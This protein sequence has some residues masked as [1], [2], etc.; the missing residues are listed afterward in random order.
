TSSVGTPTDDE[1]EP[2][3]ETPATEE[4][5][6]E[7]T[8]SEQPTVTEEEESDL[9]EQTQQ[10]LAGAYEQLED[11][12]GWTDEGNLLIDGLLAEITTTE[13]GLTTINFQQVS[14]TTEDGGTEGVTWVATEHGIIAKQ[15]GSQQ[16]AG[17][18]EL[19]GDQIQFDEGTPI[20]TVLAS[21]S[22][23]VYYD[24]A[25]EGSPAHYL[26]ITDNQI[27]RTRDDG[28]V[29]NPWTEISDNRDTGTRT[30]LHGSSDEGEDFEAN[31]G[32]HYNRDGNIEYVMDFD[33][34]R[35]ELL[36]RSGR[37][38]GLAYQNRD[39]SIDYYVTNEDGS[40]SATRDGDP[41]TNPLPERVAQAQERADSD[42]ATEVLQSIYTATSATR[43]FPALSNLIFGGTGVQD[44]LSDAEQKF[45]PLLGEVW[46][47]A[48]ICE[49]ARGLDIEPEGV[50]ILR[51]PSGIDNAVAS[52][53]VER[54]GNPS[55]ILCSRNPDEL[56][57]EEFV[58]G[59]D[60]VCVEQFCYL[61][62]ENGRQISEDPATGYFYKITWG[63]K[64][65]ADERLTPFR[66][67][68]AA[69]SFNVYL[70][71]GT[72][73]GTSISDTPLYRKDGDINGPIRLKNGQSDN[74][75]KIAYST[76]EYKKACIVW[77]QHPISRG[78]REPGAGIGTNVE[79]PDLCYETDISKVGI[80]N[81]EKSG[82]QPSST[83]SGGEVE[84]LD[85]Y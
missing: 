75:L 69:V 78:D 34:E 79:M 11:R 62:D 23:T 40:L 74:Q 25:E 1:P 52:I 16:E 10:D 45:T 3:E 83:V 26:E 29:I 47:P 6:E 12:I 70:T 8:S 77:D 21:E 66:D 17:V 67:E 27:I 43:D 84:E 57:E 55:P 14:T 44:W 80:V 71:E 38:V 37:I 20:E 63:V 76:A 56:A 4:P 85:I 18:A 7:S 54:S 53:Q 36:D 35:I 72:R 32:L 42:G 51:T 9:R 59:R 15:T 49:N 33:D 82:N 61:T 50:A 30:V 81:W 13:N 31:N 73:D 41:I 58:C 68:K 19:F 22:R 5:T 64:A 39:G 60:Q 65:P 46:F 48:L 2:A 24:D 28:T